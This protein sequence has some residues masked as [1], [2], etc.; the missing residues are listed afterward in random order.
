MV[1]VVGVNGGGKTTSL[2]NAFVLSTLLVFFSS[3]YSY[4]L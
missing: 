4:N 3:R 1:M 2:G